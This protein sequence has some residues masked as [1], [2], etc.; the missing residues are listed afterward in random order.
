LS[1]A[2]VVVKLYKTILVA[3]PVVSEEEVEENPPLSPGKASRL[4]TPRGSRP[5]KKGDVEEHGKS[6]IVFIMFILFYL[7]YRGFG[8]RV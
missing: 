7:E 1:T 3:V 5:G 6:W 8:F 2:G 4:T